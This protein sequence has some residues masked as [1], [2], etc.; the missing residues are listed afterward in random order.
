[1][2]TV[3]GPFGF[4]LCGAVT[5]GCL[6]G[7]RRW[8]SVLWYGLSGAATAVFCI[9]LAVYAVHRQGGAELWNDVVEWQVSSR[10]GRDRIF[11]YFTNAM[12]SFALT[13]FF[14]MATLVMKRRRIFKTPL[15]MLLGWMLLP[16]LLLSIPGGKHLRYMTPVIPAFALTA[17]Y[18]YLNR[19]DSPVSKAAGMTIEYLGKYIYPVLLAATVA[20]MAVVPALRLRIR[21]YF[22][23]WT[24]ALLL[25]TLIFVLLRNRRGELM[26]L[27]NI[28]CLLTTFTALVMNPLDAALDG[29][30]LFTRQVESQRTG[31]LYFYRL[32]PDHDDLKYLYHMSLGERGKV[33]YLSHRT[34]DPR[35]LLCRMYPERDILSVLPEI[36]P[37]DVI[38]LLK[39]YV[40]DLTKRIAAA[41]RTIEQISPPHMRLGH[42]EIVAL[43]LK[44]SKE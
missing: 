26:P 14:A 35:L 4:S 20:V 21:Y 9:A 40:P 39:K 41:G 1:M 33:V 42:R 24:A 38:V 37:D 6:I 25:L 22:P 2:F 7:S 5:A 27:A 17:A 3:R 32:G 29:A 43:R 44:S 30:E 18:G 15:A 8:K 11:Y 12:A 16:M 31:R 36:G 13:T 28:A 34:S 19:D 10:M 23:H